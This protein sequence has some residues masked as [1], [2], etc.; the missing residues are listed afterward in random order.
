MKIYNYLF[1]RVHPQRD[2]LWDPMNPKLFKKCIKH[3]QNKN[4]IVLIEDYIMHPE[5]YK[6][7]KIA[8]VMFDDG[9]K[10]NIEYAVPILD[11]AKV[12]ASFYIV[13][14]SID[15][16][17]PTWTH[18][19]EHLFQNTSKSKLELDFSF[20][21]NNLRSG[22][23]SSNNNRL[24]FAKKLIPFLKTIN[25]EDREDVLSSIQNCFNDVELPKIM[26]NWDD[27]RSLKDNG[28]YIGSHTVNHPMLGTMNNLEKQKY[29]LEQSAKR[30]KEELG[31]FPKTISYPVGSYN[32]T[33]IKLSKETGYEIGL[34]VKQSVYHPEKDAVFEIPRIELYNES[35]WKTKMRISNSL[36]ELKKAIRYR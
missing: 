2:S 34:A 36:E 11:E 27:I 33:T 20:L 31:Y 26:M 23:F 24:E 1:H 12:K 22:Q 5:N 21:P 35:W 9:Y 7:Q 4:D 28:H 8:T 13:T 16:N 29:E 15:N 18:I 3:I 19:L 25:H 17:K 32:E 14:D 6:G 10:D 30:I